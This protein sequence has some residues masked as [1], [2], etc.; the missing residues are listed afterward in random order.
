[1]KLSFAIRGYF[2]DRSLELAETTITG[3]RIYFDG[4]IAFIGD[5]D[6]ESITRF[7]V[8]EFLNHLRDTNEVSDHTLYDVRA[9]LSTLWTW[10]GTE[11][12]IPNIVAKVAKPTYKEP[13]IIPYSKDEIKRLIDAA[14]YSADWTT[15]NGRNVRSKRN[16]AARDKAIILT[17]LDTGIR[18]SELCALTVGDYDEHR[19][20]LHIRHGKGDK[21]R[22]VVA[23]RR[24]QKAIWRYLA[25]RPKAKDTEPLFATNTGEHSDRHNLYRMVVRCGKRANV[26]DAGCHRFRHTFAIEFLRNGGNVFQLQELLGHE[27]VRTV[28]IYI[29]IAERDIDNAGR[30]SPADHWGV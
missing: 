10:A 3:Y 29:K 21:G 13:E 6:I 19:G 12:G 30:H 5:K 17:L 8:I 27:D 20:R 28:L 25:S 9:R 22:F 2:L 7:D 1:M 23:G 14:E 11:L 16:T 26:K 4:F 15:R 18:A 24:C